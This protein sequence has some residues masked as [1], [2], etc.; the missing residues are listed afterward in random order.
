MIYSLDSNSSVSAWK[1]LQLWL[2][3]QMSSHIMIGISQS[4]RVMLMY[5]KYISPGW[6]QIKMSEWVYIGPEKLYVLFSLTCHCWLSVGL[7]L[8]GNTGSSPGE[9]TTC[10]THCNDSRETL[11]CMTDFTQYRALQIVRRT[12]TNRSILEFS[13]HI[14]RNRHWLA[15]LQYLIVSLS[16]NG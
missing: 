16:N 5:C 15:W 2:H 8:L 13:P 10:F 11:A 4:L 12:D 1:L 7:P 9:G 14:K 6:K 3:L